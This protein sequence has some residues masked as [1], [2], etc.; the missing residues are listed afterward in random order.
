M[1][2]A[3]IFGKY[4]AACPTRRNRSKCGFESGT[5]LMVK[6]SGVTTGKTG[7]YTGVDKKI[8]GYFCSGICAAYRCAGA[9][10]GFPRLGN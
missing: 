7:N 3:P 8:A 6:Q 2:G 1:L 10:V 4:S 9:A 5:R